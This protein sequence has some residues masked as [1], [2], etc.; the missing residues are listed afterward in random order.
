MIKL[1]NR[2]HI[3]LQWIRMLLYKFIV[4][5]NK[6]S[7]NKYKY[8]YSNDKNKKYRYTL[9]IKIKK[10]WILSDDKK[11]RYTIMIKKIQIQ[12]NDKNKNKPQWQK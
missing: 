5:F 6:Y 11:N 9:M 3:N 4:H 8:T 1:K 12:S 10:M 2:R 7:F